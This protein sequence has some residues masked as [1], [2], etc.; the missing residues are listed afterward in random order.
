MMFLQRTELVVLTTLSPKKKLEIGG[1]H[2]NVRTAQHIGKMV[3]WI[4]K[5]AEVDK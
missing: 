3:T 4:V 5:N 2:Q 1:S